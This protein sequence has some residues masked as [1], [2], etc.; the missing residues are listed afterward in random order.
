MLQYFNL[1]DALLR[2]RAAT[3]LNREGLY[4]RSSCKKRARDALPELHVH[5][6]SQVSRQ[7]MR[8]NEHSLIFTLIRPHMDA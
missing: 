6:L 3:M 5:V 7:E 1:V 2:L 8:D 4:L